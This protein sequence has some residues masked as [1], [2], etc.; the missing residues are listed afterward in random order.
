MPRY[1]LEFDDIATGAV[2]NTYKT[3]ASL[4]VADTAGHRC[5]LRALTVGPADDSPPDVN[6]G[7]QLNRVS[8]ISAGSA[9]TST[10]VSGANMA[11]R[12]PGSLDSIVT[13][14]I[15]HSA[16]PTTYDTEPVWAGAIN[17]RGAIVKE[18]GEAE[19]P[20]ATQD[21]LLGLLVAP[22]TAAAVRCSGSLEFESY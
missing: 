19:A 5:R 4:L 2:A 14:G 8:D 10:A 6:I 20:I 7:L 9:G 13:G 15:D 12:D 21:M 22:R 3:L 11:K 16:E 1:T 17:A 18:W